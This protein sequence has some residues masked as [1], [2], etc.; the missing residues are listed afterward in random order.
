MVLDALNWVES[1]GGTKELVNISNQNLKIVED[2]IE[3]VIIL[4]LCVKIK[5]LDLQQVLQF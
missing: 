2:W 5:I 3:K 1:V 4:N